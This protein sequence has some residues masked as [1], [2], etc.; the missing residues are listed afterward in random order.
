MRVG[1]SHLH[2]AVHGALRS[3]NITDEYDRQRAIDA[4]PQAGSGKTVMTV[5]PKF[6]PED[7]VPVDIAD[8]LSLRVKV[9][10]CTGYPVR[11]LRA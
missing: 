8:H 7:A 1:K 4:M 9:V 10:D 11:G 2:P 3:P 6:I 5:E